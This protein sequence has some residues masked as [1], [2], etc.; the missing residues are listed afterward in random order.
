MIDPRYFKV[1]E[2][3]WFYIFSALYFSEGVLFSKLVKWEVK[4]QAF[5]FQGCCW[6]SVL[7]TSKL[8]PWQSWERDGV[9]PHESHT[10]PEL[11]TATLDLT[12][13]GFASIQRLSFDD[14]FLRA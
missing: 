13:L 9:A 11:P 4:T 2:V 7:S 1:F 10:V 5:I 8:S 12:L 6:N 3:L 14:L